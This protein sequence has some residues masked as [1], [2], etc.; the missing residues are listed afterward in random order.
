MTL[1]VRPSG[2]YK[3]AIAGP[4]W[5]YAP[6]FA[7]SIRALLCHGEGWRDGEERAEERR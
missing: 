1:T 4:N 7:P 5:R 6:Y 2:V 3:V